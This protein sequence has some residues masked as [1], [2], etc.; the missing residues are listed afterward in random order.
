[1]KKLTILANDQVVYEIDREQVLGVEQ[2]EFLDSMDRSMDR[3]IKLHGELIP[4]P[5]VR[6]RATFVA[7]NLFKALQQDNV[8]IATASGA[9]LVNR[10]PWLCEVHAKD[11]ANRVVIELAEELLN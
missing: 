10:C 1:M 3:G 7:M 6:Q 5:D 8:A 9:Y 11:E 2:Q 4:Q